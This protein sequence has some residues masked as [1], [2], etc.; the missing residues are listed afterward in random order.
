MLSKVEVVLALQ[1]SCIMEED[2]V[3]L[4]SSCSSMLPE[5]RDHDRVKSDRKPEVMG[6]AAAEALLPEGTVTGVPA[7]LG[8][9]PVPR[10]AGASSML[11]MADAGALA[12]GGV[13]VASADAMPDEDDPALEV[14]L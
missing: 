10:W 8:V 11:D 1:G 9:P 5:V 6:V 3:C 2:D 4:T 14:E 13:G 12:A 7:A